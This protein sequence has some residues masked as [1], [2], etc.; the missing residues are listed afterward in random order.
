MTVALLVLIVF[1]AFLVEAALGFGATVVAV[2]LGALVVPIPELLPA[3]VPLNIVLSTF[4]VVRY[5]QDVDWGLLFRKILPLMGIGL[6]FGLWI[7]GA[8]DHRLL[9]RSFGAFVVIVSSVELWRI[10]RPATG[11][12]TPLK[13]GTKAGLLLSGGVIHGAFATGGPMA[14]Y[15]AGRELHDKG[16]FRSTLSALW[17]LLNLA[18]IAGYLVT[19]VLGWESARL[20]AILAVPLAL[21]LLAGDLLHHRVDARSFRTMVYVLLAI[22]GVLLLAMA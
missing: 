7:F 5:R 2:S 6:P 11:E 14:V 20:T 18:L 8:G 12:P 17:L 3:F 9:S 21:G 19:G 4:L 10:V 22:A 15:V 16:A 1:V 13:A